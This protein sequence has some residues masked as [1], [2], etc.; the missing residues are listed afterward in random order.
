MNMLSHVYR[1]V[2]KG[3]IAR[4]VAILVSG[5]ILA[6]AIT[7]CTLPVITRMYSPAEIGVVSLFIA[8]AGFWFSSLSLRYESAV[9]IADDDQEAQ[10]VFRIGIACVAI[11]TLLS[12]PLLLLLVYK[13]VLGFGLLPFWSSLVCVPVFLGYGLFVMHRS[14]ALRRGHLRSI[15]N[16]SIS[17]SASNAAVRIIFGLFGKGLIGL[18]L[19]EIAG[20]WGAFFTLNRSTYMELAVATAHNEINWSSITAAAKRYVKF[21]LYELPSVMVDQLAMALP[22]PIIAA[23]HG[24]AAAGWFGL[25]RLLVAIPNSQ[26]GSAVGDV[27]QMELA[28]HMR[29]C[30]HEAARRLFFELLSRLA[31]FGLIPLVGM[32]FVGPLL[33]P[34][35]FGHGWS[36]MGAIV[37]IIAPWMYAALIVASLSR[38]LSVIECQEYKLIYDIII[39]LFVALAYYASR[40]WILNL[41]MTVLLISIAN[42]LGYAIYMFIILHVVSRRLKLIN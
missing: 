5:T 37:A 2:P 12:A 41:N 15:S 29:D 1:L 25:A 9:L 4:Y 3:Q 17:R 6:Q 13:R 11:M 31:I 22:L 26:I 32:I 21:P 35:A 36:K 23:L 8:Y 24:A 19:A 33:V 16:A 42:I 18:F 10:I 28:K 14:L 34:W 20:A 38:I 39:L 27:F 30:N 7:A 40:H